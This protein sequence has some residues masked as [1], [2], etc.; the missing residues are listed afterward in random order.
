MEATGTILILEV[1]ADWR[2][3]MEEEEEDTNTGL[4]ISNSSQV[5]TM[6]SVSVDSELRVCPE[7]RGDSLQSVNNHNL[8][9]T[10]LSTLV[11]FTHLALVLFI[12]ILLYT[13][14]KVESMLLMSEYKDGVRK[15]NSFTFP[16]QSWALVDRLIHY[17]SI[18]GT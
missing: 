14:S 11:G 2:W 18:S 13:L 7:W 16:S 3:A 9:F 4:N 5:V 15:T 10:T 6:E 12:P 1:E 8:H 17:P